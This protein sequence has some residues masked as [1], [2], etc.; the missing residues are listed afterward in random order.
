MSG[1]VTNGPYW[2][3]FS[4]KPNADGVGGTYERSSE[5]VASSLDI[6]AVI[7]GILKDMV[8]T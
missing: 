7:T 3:F 5:L 8:R 4:F 1:A 6:R 2:M